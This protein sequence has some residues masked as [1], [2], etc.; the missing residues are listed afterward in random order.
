MAVAQQAPFE[1]A[2]DVARRYGYTRLV[3]LI[4][5]GQLSRCK[6]G[7]PAPRMGAKFCDHCGKQLE[8]IASGSQVTSDTSRSRSPCREVPD[9]QLDA[10]EEGVQSAQ[11]IHAFRDGCF[12][13]LVAIFF[14]FSACR[15]SA[16]F[17][18]MG[19][20]VANFCELLC[21]KPW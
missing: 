2:L 9:I 10:S 16:R 15:S 7:A 19:C 3:Q 17:R 13:G 20:S 4:C 14:R 11:E 12:F 18:F 8:S 6:C 21:H 1:T 5:G